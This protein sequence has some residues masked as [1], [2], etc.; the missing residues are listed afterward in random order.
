[1]NRAE[2]LD[3][4]D[5][6]GERELQAP[7]QQVREMLAGDQE[8]MRY[9]RISL[10]LTEQKKEVELWN[11]FQRT[12]S[13][14]RAALEKHDSKALFTAKRLWGFSAAG[15][16]IALVIILFPFSLKQ[17]SKNY[18]EEIVY[19]DPLELTLEI[20]SDFG[21]DEQRDMGALDCYYALANF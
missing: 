16:V 3:W 7:P 6:A 14:C 12:L 20:V 10:K 17:K 5:N 8:C 21:V 15:A 9:Y 19:S 2:V 1:M 18:T 4:I 13:G 11:K